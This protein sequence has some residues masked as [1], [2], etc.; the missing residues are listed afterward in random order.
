MGQKR[1]GGKLAY[2]GKTADD[3]DGQRA[4]NARLDQRDDLLAGRTPRAKGEGFTVRDLCNRFLA[5]KEQAANPR[6]SRRGLGAITSS[7]AT[8]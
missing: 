1:Y 5:A 6:K 3:P 4:L 2:F 8:A 7:R